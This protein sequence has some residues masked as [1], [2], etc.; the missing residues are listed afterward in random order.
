M[1]SLYQVLH[2]EDEEHKP[3]SEAQ[4][5]ATSPIDTKTGKKLRQRTAARAK[6]QDK[7]RRQFATGKKRFTEGK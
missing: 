3:L 4:L 7:K 1:R 5:S 6:E 2:H